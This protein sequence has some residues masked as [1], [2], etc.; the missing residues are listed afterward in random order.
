MKRFLLS[1]ALFAPFLA[2]AQ[3]DL[4]YVSTYRTSIFDDGAAEIVTYD[5]TTQRLIFTNAGNNEVEWLDFSDP[6]SLTSVNVVDMDAYGDGVNSVSASNGFIAVAVQA[7]DTEDPGTVV[8]FDANGNFVAQVEVGVLPDMVTFTPDGQKVI[9]ANEG[10][11]DDDYEVDPK[12]SVSIIDVSGGVANV[13]QGNVTTL[14]FDGVTIPNGVRIF[15]PEDI[16]AFEDDFQDED[17][18]QFD[19]N[20]V[21]WSVFNLMGG[22]RTWGEYEFP[23]GSGSLYARI[24]GFDGGCQDNED[25]LVSE[26]IDI[27]SFASAEVSFSSA[28]NFNGPVLELLVSTDY[29]QGSPVLSATWDTLSAQVNWPAVD[30]FTW[31]QSGQIDLTN[32]VGNE[33]TLAFMYTSSTAECSTWQIDSLQVVGNY[34]ASNNLEPEYVAVSDDNSTAYVILQENN[35]LAVV[36]LGNSTISAVLPLGYKDHSVAGNGLDASDRDAGINITTH[37][38]FGMYQPDAIAYFMVGGNGYLLSAN[39]GDARDYD[40]YAEEERVKDLTL[41]AA[42]FPN[43]AVLQEDSVLGRLTVTSSMGDTDDDGEY[44]ELYAFGA[45]SFSVWNATTGAL[46]WDS[47]D[48]LEQQTAAAYPNDFNANNDEND[49]FESRSDNKGPE[50]E[51]V[52]V[53]HAGG[54]TYAL[55]GLERIGGIMLYDVTTPT[56]PTFIEYE[57][58]RDFSVVNV[59]SSSDVTNDSV[60]DL[61]V[62]DILYISNSVSPDGK[63]YVVT[64]NEVSGTI[65]VF[66]VTGLPD[67]SSVAENGVN[68]EA[69][70]VY[71]NPTRMGMIRT[72]MVDTY[73][74]YD[75][76]GKQL[77]TFTQTAVLPLDGLQKGVYILRNSQGET[78]RITKL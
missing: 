7:D 14:T 32:Y 60:G 44:E 9:T 18:I 52:E 24:S 6:T 15:G 59:E 29:T 40:A 54:N 61:G 55:V 23:P 30:G 33:V 2:F 43:A 28:Y 49:S 77:N 25:Y 51:A 21:N 68:G 47:G 12:G 72:N 50:P 46:V 70:K 26:S 10:E 56:A 69:W 63:H 76:S 3:P 78:K 4:T 31:T 66:E 73:E 22:S 53:M 38:V 41:D 39:E 11:P 36:N 37:P 20:F 16:V 67:G 13:T 48:E 74:L 45:R 8:F 65:S 17:G 75:L 34:D 62:E 19:T 27:T 58:N 64:S 5:S 42:A 1:A 71:P 57:N 35:A